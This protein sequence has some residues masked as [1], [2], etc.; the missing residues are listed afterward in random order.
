MLEN[1]RRK[2]WFVLFQKPD[3]K[4]VLL[5]AKMHTF[6]SSSWPAGR[7]HFTR[8]NV[9]IYIMPE[10]IFRPLH[11]M[12]RGSEIISYNVNS[13]AASGVTNY[14]NRR[15]Y[16]ASINPFY[17]P[18]FTSFLCLGKKHHSTQSTLK[19]EITEGNSL[20]Q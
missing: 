16:N 5:F 15:T 11:L 20:L 10:R 18:C 6:S 7:P 3:D 2:I 17:V 8:V 19:A 1:E 4:N 13:K 12:A 14:R 9:M